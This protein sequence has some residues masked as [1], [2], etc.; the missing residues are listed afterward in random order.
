MIN[1]STLKTH[2]KEVSQAVEADNHQ[3]DLDDVYVYGFLDQPQEE[4]A[5]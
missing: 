3:D 5:D 1:R 4:S 2:Q